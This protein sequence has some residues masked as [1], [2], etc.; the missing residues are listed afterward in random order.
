MRNVCFLR[1]QSRVTCYAKLSSHQDIKECLT[2]ERRIPQSTRRPMPPISRVSDR[3]PS[4][5]NTCSVYMHVCARLH[6]CM[7]MESC[8]GFGFERR[9]TGDAKRA[10]ARAVMR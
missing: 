6:L 7:R 9:L 8:M 1:L 10:P 2:P 5:R 4:W 3:R